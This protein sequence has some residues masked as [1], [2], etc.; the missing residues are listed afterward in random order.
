MSQKTCTQ[1]KSRTVLQAKEIQDSSIPD[2][3][4]ETNEKENGKNTAC[5][6]IQRSSDWAIIG[7]RN[8]PKRPVC[9]RRGLQ[10][11][12]QGSVQTCR[13]RPCMRSQATGP[14]SGR[15][16]WVSSTLP[17]ASWLLRGEQPFQHRPPR[18]HCLAPGPSPLEPTDHRLSVLKH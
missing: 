1:G 12:L 18:R 11:G 15:K 2:R 5:G 14:C 10:L 3:K 17:F 7:I 9:W 16:T 13:G 8:V 4:P 6:Q